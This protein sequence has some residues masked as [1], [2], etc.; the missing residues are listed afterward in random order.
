M[1]A[2]VSTRQRMHARIVLPRFNGGDLLS[3]GHA[4]FR[5]RLVGRGAS[6][7]REAFVA[8]VTARFAR[9]TSLA[10]SLVAFVAASRASDACFN[11]ATVF[12]SSAMRRQYVDVP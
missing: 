6:I 4:Y 7:T 10:V 5:F 11:R 1:K 2:V 9:A 12:S 3:V 8:F